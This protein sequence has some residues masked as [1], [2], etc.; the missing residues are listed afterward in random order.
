MLSFVLLVLETTAVEGASA[1]TTKI[2]ECVRQQHTFVLRGA[3]HTRN[4]ENTRSYQYGLWYRNLVKCKGIS[5]VSREE[6]GARSP[7]ADNSF[8][9]NGGVGYVF[10]HHTQGDKC[11]S[12]ENCAAITFMWQR[13]HQEC[14]EWDDIGYNFIIGFKGTVFVGRGWEQTGA[15]TVGFNDKS[16]SYGFVGDYSSQV[17]DELM[18]QAARNLTECGIQMQKIRANYTLHGQRD[19]DCRECPGEAFYAFMQNMSHFGGKLP[20]YEC[21][22]SPWK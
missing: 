11:F 18:L 17:P 10:Y 5:F 7:K 1:A 16:V 22:P 4:P 19:A 14:Q 20:E 6:W 8:N 15:H 12:K 9:K 3:T 13:V 21:T 2:S